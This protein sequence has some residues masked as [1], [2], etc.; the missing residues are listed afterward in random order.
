MSG[1]LVI[2]SREDARAA[3]LKR[4]FTG[5]PCKHGHVGEGSVATGKCLECEREH[6]HK[7]RADNPE[8]W[9]AYA[10]KAY[11][12]DLEANRKKSREKGRKRNAAD[13]AMQ[14]RK[15]KRERALKLCDEARAAGLKRFFTGEPCAHEHVAERLVSSG[16]CV[17]CKR[18]YREKIKAADPEKVREYFRKHYVDNLEDRAEYGRKR[19]LDNSEKMN[20]ESRKR[21]EDNPEKY[22]EKARDRYAANPE[23]YLE[24]ERKRRE[25]N[26]E[27]FRGYRRK[28]QSSALG[29]L[30]QQC[31]YVADVMNLH[32][33][34]HSK[35][36]E[37]DYSPVE[38]RAHLTS[39]LPEGM[40]YEEARADGYHYDHIVPL[41]V[42][43]KT[44]PMDEVGRMVAYKMSQDLDNLRMIPGVDNMQKHASMGEPYQ[45]AVLDILKAK[46]L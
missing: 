11:L 29:Q 26:P 4:F 35:L 13:P 22:K 16:E 25:A 21:Y 39:T 43:N 38:H 36:E 12:A 8:K 33:L 7:D 45:L 20:E 10:R 18:I 32:P 30:R 42:I 2:I 17:E 40:T 37:L 9:K 15:L 6:L 46:Y 28:S 23:K 24:R 34:D 19:Y 3:G 14:E 1:S 31:K 27:T 41:S 5:E 44:C